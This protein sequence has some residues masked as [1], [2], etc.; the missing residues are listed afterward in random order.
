MK[1]IKNI[2]KKI[3]ASLLQT[4]AVLI[5]ITLITFFILYMAP[6]NPAEIWLTGGD[7]NVGQISEEAIKA[8]EEKMGLD[9]PFFV[10]YG[11][12]LAKVCKGD[13]GISM[14]TSRPVAEELAEHIIP[15]LQL[16]F[17]MC[18]RDSF[19]DNLFQTFHVKRLDV[20]DICC[21]RVSHD[22]CRIG[23]YQYN[24]IS[25]FTKRFAS[26]CSGIVK[27]ACLSDNNRTGANNQYFMYVSSFRHI[28]FLLRYY[29]LL[30]GKFEKA[31]VF[32]HFLTNLL[33]RTKKL[34]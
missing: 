8:Q 14:S 4:V 16:T 9:K 17:K 5:G 20:C 28:I 2:L 27:F 30:Y 33:V 31:Q 34:R 26:L 19:C 1:R 3:A 6:G 24:L 13:M 23:I 15:T 25:Q 12:W 29:Y 18:I 11:N 21:L 22:S 7:A 10:Q 32:L